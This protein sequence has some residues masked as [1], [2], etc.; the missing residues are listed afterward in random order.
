MT[1][2]ECCTTSSLSLARRRCSKCWRASQAA[3]RRPER[4]RQAAPPTHAR[5][6]RAKPGCAGNVRR[7]SLSV[8]YA[9]SV[10][11]RARW[12]G[13]AA[14]RSRSGVLAWST[15]PAPR[16]R[17]DALVEALLWCALY[18][19]ESARY[20]EHT[21]VDEAVKACGLIEQ[22]PAKGYV[23]ALLRG[24]LRQRCALEAQLANQP[25]AA[26][27]HPAWWID[28]VRTGYP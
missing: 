7:R 3:G 22:W 21:V 25:Q 23:N 27:Q 11:R 10:H 18:A 16:G 12:R 4:S 2:P 28:L 9:R 19:L 15:A 26:H 6:R 14:T 5:S 17:P 20:A 13:S 1:T 8:R 24:F